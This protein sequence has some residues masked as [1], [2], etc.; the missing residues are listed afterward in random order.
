VGDAEGEL[1]S[2]PGRRGAIAAVVLAAGLGSR[3]GG[4]KLAAPLDGR[5]VVDHVLGVTRAAVEAGVLASLVVVAGSGPKA[6]RDASTVRARAG[7]LGYTIVE[8]DDPGAGLGRSVRLGL[9][10]LETTGADA[11]LMVLGDQPRVRLDVVRAIADRWRADR[12]GIVIPRYPSGRPGNPV[13]LDRSVWPLAADLDGDVGMV[14]VARARPD[15]V[16][17]VDVDGAN[18]DID[19]PDDLAS[20]SSSGPRPRP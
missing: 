7:S 8:N 20:V 9:A 13:L 1:S 5:P 12:P 6:A 14:V 10:A 3:F 4:G 2:P 19:T 15:L 18:P 17:Y 11:A 16:S